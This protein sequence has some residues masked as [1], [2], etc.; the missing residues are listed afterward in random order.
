MKI[1]Y[2]A[3]ISLSFALI[4]TF[5]LVCDQYLVP[6]M[7]QGVFTAEGALTFQLDDFPAY[8]RLITHA[9]GHANWDHLLSNFT[10]IL[11]LGPVLEEKYGSGK[12]AL[13][14]IMTT[15]INGILNAFFFPT[16]LLGASGI[17]FM[18]ILL[19]SFAG[20]KER[21]LPVSFLAILGLYLVREVI[22]IVNTDDISQMSHIVGGGCGAVYGI[23]LNV[24][25][26]KPSKKKGSSPAGPSKLPANGTVIQ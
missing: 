8:I 3:P 7:I 25:G 9:F 1:K 15:L 2:N 16:E 21:E 4:C 6:G 12:I 19:T 14:M 22:N 10:F 20:T 23:F 17:A 11:L 24:I 13:L 5:I 18:M 26:T